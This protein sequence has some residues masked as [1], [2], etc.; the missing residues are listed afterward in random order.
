MR[1]QS[2]LATANLLL[3]PAGV[4]SACYN[5]DGTAAADDSYQPCNASAEVSAC[6]ANNK[7][8]ASD[9][10]LSSGLCY[11]QMENFRGLIYMN[12]CTDKTGLSNNCPHFCPDGEYLVARCQYSLV[13]KTPVLTD[14]L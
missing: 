2:L 12:G 8:A 11:A 13:K 10:C 3:L 4:R 6:C 5:V 1:A 9:I 7:G 14:H